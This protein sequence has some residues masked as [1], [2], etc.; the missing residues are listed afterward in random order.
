MSINLIKNN[1]NNNNNKY[2]KIDTYFT[3]SWNNLQNWNTQINYIVTTKG[4]RQVQENCPVIIV[5][6]NLDCVDIYPYPREFNRPVWASRLII[7]Y[8][9]G[10]LI[11]RG[12]NY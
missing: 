2:Q 5:L 10:G 11:Q 1:N 12:Q 3:K 9:T 7:Y 4:Q 6:E 8:F